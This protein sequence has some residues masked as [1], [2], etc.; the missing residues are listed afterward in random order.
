VEVEEKEIPFNFGDWFGIDQ[1]D[2]YQAGALKSI[3]DV[4]GEWKYRALFAT[5]YSISR[6]PARPDQTVAFQAQSGLKVFANPGAL[7]RARVVH[8]AIAAANEQSVI[9]TVINPATDLQRTV[10]LQGAAP[11]LEP[12]DAGSVAIKRYRPAHVVMHADLACRSM[13]ILADAWFPGWKA[14]VDGKPAQIHAAYNVV[15]G[16]V[17]DG[18][19]HEVALVYR[20]ASLYTGAALALIGIA[21]CL[22]LRFSRRGEWP[23]Q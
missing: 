3:A 17:V 5:N 18:G 9:A 12:C 23:A 19:Q 10:V 7:P 11:Q 4:Q 21:I 13:V 6:N 20:P 2:G 1:M 8:Q 16:V 22:F 14:Y 15:R